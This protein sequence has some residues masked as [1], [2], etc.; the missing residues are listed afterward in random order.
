MEVTHPRRTLRRKRQDEWTIINMIQRGERWLISFLHSSTWSREGGFARTFIALS[1]LWLKLSNTS[2]SILFSLAILENPAWS[3][4]LQLVFNSPLNPHLGVVLDRLQ[5]SVT[6]PSI[7]SLLSWVPVS[8]SAIFV[9]RPHPPF[10]VTAAELPGITWFSSPLSFCW[11]QLLG[12]LNWWQ[13][14]TSSPH[15]EVTG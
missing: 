8:V 12:T 4:Y 11:L 1:I 2:E 7:W 6:L 14:S 10:L 9:S 3:F 15:H 13:W 5:L